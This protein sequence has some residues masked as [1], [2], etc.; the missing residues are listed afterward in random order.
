VID[1]ALKI[2]RRL[3]SQH[4][5]V[6]R[7]PYRCTADKLSIGIGRNLDDRGLS[8]SE[9]EYLFENDLQEA[10]RTA[11]AY[12]YFAGLNEAR[13]AAILDMAFQLGSPR[14]AGFVRMHKNMEAGDYA[15]AADECLD[16]RYAKQVPARAQRI[17]QIIRS[18]EHE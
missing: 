9:I 18:G 7:F 8:M 6:R 13:Q 1:E 16:S 5:G 4:E 2:A 17:A 12:T 15:A 10:R 3:I 11:Q 14:L